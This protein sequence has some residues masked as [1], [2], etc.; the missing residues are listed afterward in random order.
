MQFSLFNRCVGHTGG[1][2]DIQG[3]SS[4]EFLSAAGDRFVVSWKLDSPEQ[5]TLIARAADSIYSILHLPEK[6]ELLIGQAKGEIHVMDLNFNHEKR[7]LKINDKGIFAL[8]ENKEKSKIYVLGGD[9]VLTVLS[10]NDFSLMDKKKISSMKL[11]S[12][13]FDGKANC[14]Y[15]GCGEGKIH[16]LEDETLETI[17]SHQIAAQGFSINALVD[18][19]DELLICG[20]RDAHLRW[21]NKKDLSIV[22]EIPAHNYA[23]YKIAFSPSKSYFA[24]A[25]RDKTIKIWDSPSKHVLQRLEQANEGHLNSVN[26]LFWMND[27]TLLTAGDDRSIGIWKAV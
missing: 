5:G 25:S 22:H 10:K 4:N 6:N 26:T 15:V 1:V 24:T 23:I 19:S 13:V 21:I 11:R 17:H 2:Y 27:T 8:I 18:Y 12:L 14:L 3:I 7:L 9:G 16:Q 20:G